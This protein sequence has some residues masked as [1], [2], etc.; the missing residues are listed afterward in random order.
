M[1]NRLY[2]LS[3]DGGRIHVVRRSLADSLA[4]TL[5]QLQHNRYCFV[6]NRTPN[7]RRI[8]KLNLLKTFRYRLKTILIFFLAGGS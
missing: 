3:P 7:R 5:N 6:G 2:V 8:I 1:G 4:L